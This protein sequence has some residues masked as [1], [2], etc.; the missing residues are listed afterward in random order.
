MLL[1]E[2]LV[3][4]GELRDRALAEGV[5]AIIEGPGHVPLNQVEMNIK[6]LLIWN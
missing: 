2:Y 6:W 5:Q 1:I 4:I 3:T